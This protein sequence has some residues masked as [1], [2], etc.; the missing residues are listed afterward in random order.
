MAAPNP[1]LFEHYKPPEMVDKLCREFWT[2]VM[3]YG[4]GI[5]W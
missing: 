4:L 1:N 5:T 3:D 2:N